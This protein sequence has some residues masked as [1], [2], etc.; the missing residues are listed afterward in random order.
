M[1]KLLSTIAAAFTFASAV[2]AVDVGIKILPSYNLNLESTFSNV[3]EGTIS[4]DVIPFTIRGRDKV[5]FSAQGS[6]SILLA[7]GIDSLGLFDGDIAAGYEYR[8]NDRFSASLEGF[9][10][11]W[12]FPG[13]TKQKLPSASGLSYGARLFGSYYLT[14]A[15]TASAFAGIKQYY[16]KPKPFM[17][18][19]EL[20]LGINYNFT[21][22]LFSKTNIVTTEANMDYLFPVFYSR[23]DDH[24]FG[25]VTFVNKEDTDITD[26][27]VTVFIPQYM[28]NPGV[29]AEFPIIDRGEEFSAELK[30]FLN[31][32]ILNSLSAK[33][34]DAIVTV[35][36]RALGAQRSY[37]QT[38]SLYSLMRNNM[39]WEDDRAASAFVS[40]RDAS[41]EKTARQI[42]SYIKSET[43]PAVPYNIQY[44]AA[45]YGVLKDYG[46]NYVIDSS[47]AFTDN[48]GTAALD[49]LNYPYMTMVYHGG[50]CDDLSI[51]NCSIF[52]A[53]GIK[54]AF[55]TVP[56]HIYMAIDSGVAVANAK[57]VLVDGKYIIYDDIVWI[58]LE[59]TLTQDTFYEEWAK[60]AQEWN[61]YSKDAVII[62]MYEAWK[63]YSPVS[64][65]ESDRKI[66]LVSK[67][68]I[69]S[70]M[71]TSIR[72]VKGKCL[73]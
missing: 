46:I 20:G 61:K 2:F 33:N 3:V 45:L 26:V 21:K 30:A 48:F 47:S 28:N 36:Y 17:T 4:F 50:D 19:V 29:C 58:P 24:S 51:L 40:G 72:A 34:V 15:I 11:I 23:Y 56:G 6:G 27:E 38:L 42:A 52:E 53:V 35:N 62:P 5:Y 69:I 14:P 8:I 44:A 13:D 10:G 7:K 70:N 25:N 43:D 31:E 59:I 64:I 54:S 41:V 63:E 37:S 71:R 66:Q 57:Q 60:G 68:R 65:P 22:G 73:R 67:D 1:K 16:S 55:I 49:S 12:S 9:G 32:N 39:T 18:V